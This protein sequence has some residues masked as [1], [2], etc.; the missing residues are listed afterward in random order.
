MNK[1]C[2][3][4]CPLKDYS[5][6]SLEDKCPQCDRTYGMILT[7]AP[8]TIREYRIT[9]YLGRG[10]LGAAYVAEL[11]T[12]ARK[13]VL[14]ISPVAFYPFFNKTPFEQETNLHAR[15]SPK[16]SSYC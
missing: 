6:K 1:Y 13:H 5:E 3:F 16:C 11:G 2:C 10:F 14:K 15:T 8:A 12:F 4:F 9:R 7:S